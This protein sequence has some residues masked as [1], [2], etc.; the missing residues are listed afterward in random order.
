[1]NY[2]NLTD[3]NWTER[4]KDDNFSIFLFYEK[5]CSA[6]ES[7]FTALK[8][9]KEDAFKIDWQE[10]PELTEIFQIEAV[11]WL[12]IVKKE[13]IYFETGGRYRNLENFFSKWYILTNE[14]TK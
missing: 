8:R 10:N 1:M 6:C 4:W 5:D 11:P 2:V 9:Y 14:S 3:D 13:R 7:L 12:F